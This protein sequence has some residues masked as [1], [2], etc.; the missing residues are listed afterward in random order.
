MGWRYFLFSMGGLMLLLWAIRFFVF[1]LY[2]TPKYLMGCGKDQEA[3]AVVHK[4][5]EYNGKTS[6][7]TVERL[8]LAGRLSDKEAT[9]A[10][11]T[12]ALGAI[13]RHMAKFSANHVR[14]LFATRNLAYS[15]SILIVL[16]GRCFLDVCAS[17]VMSLTI[18]SFQALIGLAFPL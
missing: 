10:M 11:D 16:W 12:S 9:G 6:D 17:H 4:L 14:A 13:K 3:T 5:A 1:T 15:T 2:E 7:L 8:A 18:G